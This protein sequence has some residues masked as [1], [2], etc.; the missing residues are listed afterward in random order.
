MDDF[1]ENSSEW[2]DISDSDSDSNSDDGDSTTIAASDSD[3]TKSEAS[4]VP[5]V[6]I[7][8][9][10]IR[11]KYP[12][13]FF[14]SSLRKV[15]EH[16]LFFIVPFNDNQVMNEIDK[17]I[18]LYE[19]MD[20]LNLHTWYLDVQSLSWE[21]LNLLQ[22]FHKDQNDLERFGDSHGPLI[23]IIKLRFPRYLFN[24]GP[25]QGALMTVGWMLVFKWMQL[26]FRSMW[27]WGMLRQLIYAFIWDAVTRWVTI[28]VVVFLVQQSYKIW[29][30]KSQG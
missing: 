29:Y 5:T 13:L 21:H 2:E 27:G 22:P 19:N 14:T 17:L 30:R 25:V 10:T 26:G 23:I 24:K 4:T 20:Y 9:I 11:L 3:D 6:D 12:K 16:Q 18:G 1:E 8:K 28:I 15:I 7:H